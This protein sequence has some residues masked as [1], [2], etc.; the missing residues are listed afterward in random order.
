[1]INLLQWW[2]AFRL[3]FGHHPILP[4]QAP[5]WTDSDSNALAA[6]LHG[7]A[8]RKLMAR[9]WFE[10]DAV[11]S[12]AVSRP[13]GCE[14]NAGYA[15]GFRAAVARLNTISASVT[16]HPDDASQD[17]QGAEDVAERFAP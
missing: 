11:R 8:G 1:M 9:L 12:S 4:P 5:E 13:T 3:W 16:P 6:F 2:R 7:A 14:F 10:E 15:C 17:P